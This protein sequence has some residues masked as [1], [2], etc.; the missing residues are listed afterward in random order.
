MIQISNLTKSYGK[1]ALY[2]AV[3]LSIGPREKVGFVGRNGSGKSTLFRLILGEEQSDSGI[4]SIPKGYKIGTLE[5][6]LKFT[7]KTVLEEVATALSEDEIY[8]HW[9][10]EKILFGLGF[11][12]PD[13]E[14]PPESFSGGYQIRMNLAKLLVQNPHM[15]LM[16][17]PSN[18]L[19]II[20]LRWVKGWLR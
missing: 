16:D 18:Y 20:S 14:K 19:D 17:E 7:R 4:I 9:K 8:D 10:A 3:T 1:Q 2:S 12:E 6:H 13:M 5:Q 11:T 15:L